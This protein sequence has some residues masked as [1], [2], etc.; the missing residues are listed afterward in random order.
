MIT[1]TRRETDRAEN[2][3]DLVRRLENLTE[4]IPYRI[5][6]YKNQVSHFLSIDKKLTALQVK[7]DKNATASVVGKIEV[8]GRDYV[9][10]YRR[11]KLSYSD[12]TKD[13][14]NTELLFSELSDYYLS[15]GNRKAAKRVNKSSVKFDMDARK[16][17]EAAFNLM[18]SVSNLSYLEALK[19]KTEIKN[20]GDARFEEPIKSPEKEIPFDKR[21]EHEQMEKRPENEQRREPQP[22][23]QYRPVRQNHINYEPYTYNMPINFQPVPS[24]NIAPISIDVN[25]AVESA[26][27]RFEELFEARIASYLEAYKIPEGEPR[28]SSEEA[29]ASSLV[30]DAAAENLGF[31]ADKLSE[32]LDKAT[33]L[34]S[35][36]TEISRAYSE[37]E[38]KHKAAVESARALSDMQRALTREIQGIQ[39]TQKVITQDQAQV[40]E[41]QSAILEKQKEILV[42]QG[43]LSEG[44]A[45]IF[46]EQT[47]LIKRREEL[48]GAINEI[49]ALYSE[50][51]AHEDEILRRGNKALEA[52][53]ALTEKQGELTEMQR[54]ALAAHRRQVRSQKAI[55]EKAEK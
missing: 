13:I 20:E 10:A 27:D 14:K 4:E 3:W 42:A 51:A 50:I 22:R 19:E 5:K 43:E 46:E 6:I 52:Q 12:I 32:L 8:M 39:V 48:D 55:N 9:S 16:S 36:I 53:R 11:C 44:A 38:E 45:K 25:R 41:E 26:V 29:E 47:A 2:H 18:N 54:E 30:L 17:L 40:K 21:F 31:A 37:L 49:G 24:F 7:A 34:L 33:A 15:H 28:V 23:S 1:N 35:G